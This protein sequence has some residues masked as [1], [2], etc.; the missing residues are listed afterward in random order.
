MQIEIESRPSFAMADV[1]LQPGETIIAESG[2]MVAMSPG[3]S[4]ET[5]LPGAQSG[6]VGAILGFLFAVLRRLLAGESMFV[7]HFTS[8]EAGARVLL[9]PGMVGDVVQLDVG[10]A[11]VTVQATSFLASAPTVSTHLVWGGFSMLFSGEGAFF[12]RCQGRGALL[13]NSYGAIDRID[14]DGGYII[15]SGHVVGWSGELTYEMRRAGSWKSTLLSG[16]G[17]VLE[18]QG[19]GT[20]WTQSRNLGALASWITL[21]L[22]R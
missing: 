17:F 14:I 12:L 7:N 11:P 20:V 18:F 1:R 8:N 3:L 16:E 4:V 15:D 22:P 9:A 19:R 21:F 10:S 6:F 5:R 13:V 2:A